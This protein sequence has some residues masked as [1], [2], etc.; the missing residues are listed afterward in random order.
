MGGNNINV[1]NNVSTDNKVEEMLNIN[2]IVLRRYG[3]TKIKA[4]MINGC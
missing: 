3:Y 4:A 1:I 2:E